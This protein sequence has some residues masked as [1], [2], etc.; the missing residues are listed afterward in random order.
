MY[1]SAPFF[2]MLPEQD[3]KSNEWVYDVTANAKPE[4]T[5]IPSQPETAV[6][7]ALK[8]WQDAGH[9]T[10]RP[11]SIAVQLIRGDGLV[12]DTVTLSEQ[13]NWRY[14]WTGLNDRYTWT[15]VEKEL[16]GYTV[17]VTREG[18]TFVVTNSYNEEIP[19]EPTPTTPTT[20]DK[21]TTPTKPM[22]PQTGQLWWPVPVLIAAGLLFVVIGLVRRRGTTDEK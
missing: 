17:E 15:I 9:E 2:V 21:P 4:K 6:R 18:I 1:D 20:P 3:E 13:N 10:L 7:K 22:L 11:K 14:T 12:W 5:E 16:E 19:D 8:V